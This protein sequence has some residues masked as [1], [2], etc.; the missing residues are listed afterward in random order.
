MNIIYA[1]TTMMQQ[2]LNNMKHYLNLPSKEQLFNIDW[3]D[4]TGALAKIGLALTLIVLTCFVMWLLRAVG[5]YVMARNN[6]DELAWT[7]FIPFAC[8]FT[9][10]RIVGDT[11]I[12]KIKISKT[13]WVL[14]VI[15]L[16]M[17]AVPISMGFSLIIFV[18]AYYGLLYRLFE[19]QSKDSAALLIIFSIILP[20]L[21]PLFIFFL[22]NKNINKSKTKIK[23]ESPKA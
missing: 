23:T 2:N 22:R 6:K 13:E 10:G 9:M 20:I 7:S 14:P 17:I 21:Q 8:L 15:I 1:T 12:Y 3:L 4:V 16:C 19:K 5:L 11:S 18:L